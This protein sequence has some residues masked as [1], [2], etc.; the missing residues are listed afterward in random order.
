ME[1]NIITIFCL[2]DDILKTIGQKDD[3]CAKICN[4][5]ILTIGVAKKYLPA[6]KGGFNS[7]V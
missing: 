6:M 2:A 3:I 5:E 1:K 4:A 7:Y